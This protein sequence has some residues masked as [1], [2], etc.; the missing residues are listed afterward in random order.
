MHHHLWTLSSEENK[1]RWQKMNRPKFKD[2][3]RCPKQPF[4]L[5][6]DKDKF[7]EEIEKYVDQQ[8]QEN[9]ALKTEI[10]R[11]EQQN[12]SLEVHRDFLIKRY[13]K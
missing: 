2:F 13:E 11:L 4:K 7:I 6:V 12:T 3:V 10:L 5:E 9:D 1:R 8:E